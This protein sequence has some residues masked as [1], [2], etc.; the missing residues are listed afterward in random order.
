MVARLGP[1]RELRRRLHHRVHLATEC[2]LGRREAVYEVGQ[3]R[4][5]DDEQVDVAIESTARCGHRAEDEH[6]FEPISNVSKGRAQHVG[7][8]RRLGDDHP[9]FVEHRALAVRPVVDLPPLHRAGQDAGVDQRAELPLH[10]TQRAAGATRYLAH[11]ERFVEVPE[12]QTQEP[13][14]G[15]PEEGRSQGTAP[16]ATQRQPPSGMC[17]HFENDRIHFGYTGQA[18]TRAPAATSPPRRAE[19]G[20]GDFPTVSRIKG[21]RGHQ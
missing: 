1:S 16:R 6:R 7:Q 2:R 13:L 19:R 21:G 5:A 8:A 20:R 15:E 14:A 17:S 9:Q 11:V 12:E 3:G 18:V 4:G 10:R